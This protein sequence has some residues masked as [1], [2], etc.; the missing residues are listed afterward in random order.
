MEPPTEIALYAL[1]HRLLRGLSNLVK[2]PNDIRTGL[3]C[4]GSRTQRSHLIVV[5]TSPRAVGSFWLSRLARRSVPGSSANASMPACPIACD[6]TPCAKAASG[7]SELRAVLG[8]VVAKTSAGLVMYR[9]PPG[10][11]LI[12]MGLIPA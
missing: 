1:T 2:N 5:D 4:L 12:G 3:V 8:R 6:A 9:V 7:Q 11:P 10:H